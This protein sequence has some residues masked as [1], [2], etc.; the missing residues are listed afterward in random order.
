MRDWQPLLI[1]FFCTFWKIN[2]AHFLQKVLRIFF[3]HFAKNVPKILQIGKNFFSSFEICTPQL[4][5]VIGRV[6]E[7]R[8][9][10]AY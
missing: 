3:K 9:L 4:A 6:L 8:L 2:S 10:L 7:L 5:E 1:F